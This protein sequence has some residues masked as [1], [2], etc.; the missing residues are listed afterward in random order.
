M[1]N[2]K[3]NNRSLDIALNTPQVFPPCTTKYIRKKVASSKP[4]NKLNNNRSLDIALNTPQVFS[5]VYNE[6][7]K[8][9]TCKQ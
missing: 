3:H 5:A 7:H 6:V 8:E 1:S 4:I 9:K 2:K